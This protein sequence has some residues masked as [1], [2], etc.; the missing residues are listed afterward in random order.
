MQSDEEEEVKASSQGVRQCRGASMVSVS[1]AELCLARLSEQGDAMLVRLG[2][3]TER[4]VYTKHNV[5]T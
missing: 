4:T 2:I 1:E 3:A 5:G